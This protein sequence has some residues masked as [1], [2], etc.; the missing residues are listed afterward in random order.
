MHRS[1][2]A[3]HIATLGARTDVVLHA[4]THFSDGSLSPSELVAYFAGQGCSAVA[5]TD[6]DTVAGHEEAAAA[7]KRFGVEFVPGI[8]FTT[9]FHGREWHLLGYYLDWDEAA[10][11][12]LREKQTELRQ[13]I[14][15]VCAWL[16]QKGWEICYEAMAKRYPHF[17]GGSAERLPS[18]IRLEGFET[19]LFLY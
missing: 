5:V 17:V 4:H 11:R 6:H 2:A 15:R 14:E 8:E 3:E 16:S 18:T 13:R 19:K 1:E 9:V 10:F 12:R 7:A